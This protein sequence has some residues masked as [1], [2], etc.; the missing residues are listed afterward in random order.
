MST[1]SIL[2]VALLLLA[3]LGAT[4]RAADISQ[5]AWLGGCWKTETGEPGSGEHWL[6]L[7]GNPSFEHVAKRSKR[8]RA[9]R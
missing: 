6:P 3:S 1:E 7:A 8:T 4:A 2:A 5:S 9:E